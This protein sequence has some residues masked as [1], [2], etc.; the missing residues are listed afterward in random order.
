MTSIDFNKLPK[1][2]ELPVKTGAPADSNWGVFGDDDELGCVNFLSEEG[3]VEATR[4]VRRGRVFRLDMPIAYANPPLFQRPR[5]RHTIMKFPGYIGHDDKLDDYNTQEGTQWD[6]FGH[7]GHT[8]SDSFYNGVKIEEIKSGPG[9]KLGIHLWAN[10]MV[11]RGVLLN[12]FKYRNDQG[13]PLNP[14]APEWYTL[15]D[16]EATVDAQ[17]VALKPGDILMVR[18]GWLQHYLSSSE[19]EKKAM[20][21]W[22]SLRAC[23]I[24]STREVVAWLWDNRVAAL[25]T[26]CPA[27]ETW[28]WNMERGP[29]HE[30]TL[31][32]LGLP[33]GEQFNFEDL[34]ADSAEDG[35][36]ESMVVSVPLYLEGGIASPPNAVAIK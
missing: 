19:E 1:F 9:G 13:R 7:Q 15:E 33:L 23:G 25:A 8:E 5:A 16:L 3:V 31:P 24:D 12:A 20:G 10:K 11:G 26:D 17:R 35:V 29:L 30:R 22:R 18:T 6:C 21:D 28:P 34:A 36:Y 2:S 27:A 4:L 14:G 32:L